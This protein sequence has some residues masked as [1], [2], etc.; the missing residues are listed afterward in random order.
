M[1]RLSKS[2]A[3][4]ASSKATSL[5]LLK[6]RMAAIGMTRKSLSRATGISY[7]RIQAICGGSGPRP[8]NASKKLIEIAVALPIWSSPE[9]YRALTQRLRWE[10]QKGSQSARPTTS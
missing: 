7:F 5:P 9:E 8:G 10:A 6:A 4:D 3:C 1:P 2:Q